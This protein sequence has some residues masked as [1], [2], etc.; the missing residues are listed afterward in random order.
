MNLIRKVK[1]IYLFEDINSFT[2]KERFFF[3]MFKGLIE[4]NQNGYYCLTGRNLL[5]QFKYNPKNNTFWYSINDI[6]KKFINKYKMDREDV[7]IFIKSRLEKYFGFKD[8]YVT[9]WTNEL[10]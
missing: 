6:E 5:F 2:E 4:S 1:L 10:K 9:I 7:S 8:V 3:D